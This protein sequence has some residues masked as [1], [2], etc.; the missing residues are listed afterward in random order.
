MIFMLDKK[1]ILDELA[2]CTD[3]AAIHDF[4]STYLGKK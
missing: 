1:K 3:E 4:H 2:A